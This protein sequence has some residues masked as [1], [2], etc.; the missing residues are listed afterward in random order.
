MSSTLF[1]QFSLIL[2]AISCILISESINLEECHAQTD[3][4]QN[5]QDLPKKDESTKEVTPPPSPRS[6][7]GI[8]GTIGK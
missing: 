6:Y 4:N 5:S 7:I 8:G 2:L 3:P 1:S